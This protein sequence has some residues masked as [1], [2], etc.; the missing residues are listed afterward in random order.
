MTLAI[1]LGDVH[2]FFLAGVA[3]L[4]L[5]KAETGFGWNLGY[6]SEMAIA[7]VDFIRGCTDD[8]GERDAPPSST[9]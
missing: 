6:A 9:S 1:A 7:G 2:Q 8:D 4:G 3:L 5:N